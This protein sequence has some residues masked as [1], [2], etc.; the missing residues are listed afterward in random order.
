M[1]RR[2][3][4]SSRRSWTRSGRCESS[5]GWRR[6]RGRRW[7]P[8]TTRTR[9]RRSSTC[10]RPTTDRDPRA[11]P[12]LSRFRAG[13]WPQN[14]TVLGFAMA[15][16][17]AQHLAAGGL[18]QLVDELDLAGVLVG[19]HP[20]LAI[21]DQLVGGRGLAGLEADERLDGLAAVVVS[22]AHD[23]HLADGGVPVERVFDVARPHLV[24]R[25]VD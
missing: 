23:R 10:R 11:Y 18:R 12:E 20:L 15:Q 16:L 19:G 1:R 25:D 9:G 14:A 2:C 21:G 7:S 22:H 24:A 17:A 8:G 3:Q 5:T 6:A 4:A 13:G